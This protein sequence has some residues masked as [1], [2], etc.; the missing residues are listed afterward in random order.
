M[1][2][3]LFVVA[4]LAGIVAPTPASA[5]AVT[6]IQKV[7]QLLGDMLAKGK[8]EKHD[9]TVMMTEFKANCEHTQETKKNEI[10]KA[11]EAI[12]Q[13]NADIQKAEADA[14]EL[15]DQIDSLNSDVDG[16]TKELDDATKVRD[17]ER[18][19]YTAA[20]L[21]YEESLDAIGRAINVLRSRSAD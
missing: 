1:A 4:V 12:M 20:H 9:E 14:A 13:L 6:P 21:D 19:N 5:A 8:Q 15:G 10:A 16:W 7:I 18:A 17:A 11:E 3:F 2:R